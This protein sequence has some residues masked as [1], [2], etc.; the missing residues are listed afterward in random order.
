M[1]MRRTRLA[2]WTDAHLTPLFMD[3]KGATK[4]RGYHS[5]R[6]LDSTA[7]SPRGR[8]EA[9]QVRPDID[10][11]P[12]LVCYALDRRVICAGRSYS[13]RAGEVCVCYSNRLAG[14]HD[15]GSPC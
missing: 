7:R 10:T 14:E 2:S 9:S 3:P 15:V 13:R 12:L 11:G 4:G 8:F 6:P 1:L 5:L